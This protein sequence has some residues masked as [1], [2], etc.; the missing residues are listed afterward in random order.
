MLNSVNFLKAAIPNI[1]KKQISQTVTDGIKKRQ[2]TLG[3]E[4]PKY[5]LEE[6]HLESLRVIPTRRKMLQYLPKNATVA[7]I[8]VANGEFSSEIL[9]ITQPAMLHLID[10][11]HTSR[12]NSNLKRSVK[13]KLSS[14]ITRG[15]VELHEGL[16]TDVGAS[17]EDNYFDWVYIDTDHTYKLTREELRIYS[18]KLKPSGFLT[19]HDYISGNWNGLVRYGVIEAVHEFCVKE[20]WELVFLTTELEISPS[21]AIKKISASI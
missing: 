6:R 19:G 15:L 4:M 20:G 21:F 14:E 17:F 8:G 13:E 3:A 5:A 18:R 2:Q 12:Y 9:R 16:S 10:A 1:I 7:E 11:W